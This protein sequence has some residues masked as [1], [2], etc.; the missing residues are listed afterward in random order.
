MKRV[1]P[2]TLLWT[3]IGSY[4]A[5]FAALSILRHRAFNTGRFDLGNMVQTVWN[6]A[7][8]NVLELTSGEGEQIS[9]LA[10]H[11]DPILAAF[12]PLWWLW[13]SPAM[14]LTVQAVAVALGALP[15]FWLARKR[16]RSD[17]AGI[18]FALSYLLYPATQWLTLNEFHPV[19]L[20]TPLLLF[21]FWY[22][23]ED[24]LAPFAVFAGLA[25][26]AKEEIGLVV[27]GYGLWYLFS[28]RRRLAGGAIAGLGVLVSALVVAIV[29]PHYNQG[30]GSAF[31]GRYEAIGGSA[32]GVAKTAFTRPWVLLEEAFGGGDVHYL[33]H[34]ALPLGGVLLLSP[35]LLVA[36]LPELAL[37]LL[38][39]VPT[40]TSIH[41]HYTAG[42]IPPLVAATV[43]GAARI[44]RRRPSLTGTLAAGAVLVAL[45]SNYKLGAVPLWSALPGG[46]DFQSD[47]AAMTAHDRVARKA[48]SLI[49][50]GAVVSAT[51][52]L[53]AH[54]SARRRVLSLPKLSDA[55]WVAADETRPSYADRSAPLP[56]AAAL[57][58]LRRS[59]SWRLVFEEDGVLVFRRVR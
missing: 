51:N 25:M 9:R 39:E 6:T 42:T 30:A 33:L 45:A 11:F 34:L 4:A 32:A 7:H 10:A 38:S 41:F 17:R 8:G 56:A 28:R 44:A 21:A 15:V 20:A 5:G 31:F 47:A 27:A 24:R 19:A 22:L 14:L 48:I 59:P 26:T 12:A 18:G 13:P 46:E 29:V 57:V 58:N 37:N 16:L 36:A 2:R 50:G 40:Q 23:D 1:P 55:T 35:L 49:P 53:G 52:S 54:L 3:A 43:L